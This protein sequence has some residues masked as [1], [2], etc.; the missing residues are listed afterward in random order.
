MLHLLSRNVFKSALTGL[1]II[2]LSGQ[3]IRAQEEL[4]VIRKKWMKYSDAPNLLYHHVSDEALHLL[5]KEEREVSLVKSKAQW[6]ARQRQKKEA[7]WNAIGKFGE[8]TPLNPQI[9]GVV[10]KEGFRIENLIYESLPGY[11]VTASLFIPD[12]VTKPAPAILFCSGHS[13]LA[14]RRDVYQ[15]PLQNLVKKGFIV[16]AIDPVSQGERLQ[17]PDENK[18]ESR[19]GSSTREHSYPAPQAFLIGQSVARYFVWDGIRGIDYLV[20]RPEVD[21][22]R[23]G[24]HGLSGGGT[25]TAYIAALDDRV[26]A[27]APSGYI[28]GYKRL[29]E[30]VGVQDGE[31]NF[32]HGLKSGIDHADFLEI[33]APKPTLIMATTRDFFNI[34][35]TREVYERVKK[36]YTVFGKPEHL[37]MVE[38]DYEH[39]Y[40]QN[41]R[42]GMYAFFQKHLSL[43]G[44]PQEEEV[45]LLTE[46]ELQKTETGQLA[47]SLKAIE[48]VFSLN[49][50]QATGRLEAL[51]KSRKQPDTHLEKVLSAARSLSGYKVP[52]KVETPVFTGRIA[53]D[54]YVIERYFIQGE[55]NYP[56]PYL[57]LLP[58]GKI[59][60]IV[61]YL[62]PD[63]KAKEAAGEMEQLVKKGVA[64]LAPDLVGTGELKPDLFAGDAHIEGVSYNIWFMATLTGRSITGIQAADLVR[65]VQGIRKQLK[66]I[67]ILAVAKGE[68]APALLHAAAFCKDISR[69][70]LSGAYLSYR[71]VVTSR[72][73]KPAYVF[74]MVP[75][76]LQAYDLPD[77]AATLAPRKLLISDVKDASGESADS[78]HCM[79]EFS[80]TQKGYALKKSEN[81][82][83]IVAEGNEYLLDEW[84]SM[85]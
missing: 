19:I 6:V 29:L 30:S 9:T 72:Y 35:G 75:G 50:R 21:A 73:Y 25:Q 33:R 10:R 59:N 40:T 68:M 85:D 16:L 46:K 51:D 5:E 8:K 52:Q 23:I 2:F 84:I 15:I 42:E 12:N 63:G 11:Y 34:T 83:K 55:G 1:G 65:L 44:S 38:G 64:V 79:E 48:T 80:I 53:R 45:T 58:E 82:L 31:Q 36:A 78:R 20:S 22:G 66:G 77:L 27:A 62:H 24:V 67:E 56:I 26:V 39:G 13:A 49:L 37:Q 18:G 32:Y 3:H 70:A 28:T 71:S 69:V 41:I 76:A 4:N 43:P 47:T 81:Q 17:Y 74:S 57:M 54:G 61:L 7:I 60:K 14:Y